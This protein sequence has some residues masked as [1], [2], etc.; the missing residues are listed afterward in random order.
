M[1]NLRYDSICFLVSNLSKLLL[2]IARLWHGSTKPEDADAYEALLKP[3]LLPGISKVPGFMGSYFLKRDL[4]G[5][6]EFI[7][8]LLWESLEALKRFAGEDY[9]ISIVPEERRQYLLKH[10]AKAAHFEVISHP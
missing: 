4:G 6:V 8:I 7:T 10:D 3:E 5:E 9:E 1:S 2:M